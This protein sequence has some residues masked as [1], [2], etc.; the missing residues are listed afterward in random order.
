MREF[1]RRGQP[2]Y[3]TVHIQ[4]VLEDA[5]ALVRPAA[6]SHGITVDLD[7]DEDLPSLHADRIQLQQVVLNLMQNALD[8]VVES[9]RRDGRVRIAAGRSHQPPQLEISVTDNGLGVDPALAVRLFT[10]LTTSKADG[11]GL[12]L[13]TCAAIVEAHGGRVWLQSGQPG[14]TVFRFTVPYQRQTAGGRP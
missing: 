3:S 4:D 1:L 11:L 10:P 8:S 13:A 7:L 5:L 9:G 14:A 2:R 6:G 12:G